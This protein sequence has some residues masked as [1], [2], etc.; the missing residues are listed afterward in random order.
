M[1]TV[2]QALTAARQRLADLPDSDPELDAQVLLARLLDKDRSWLYAWPEASL[3]AGQLAAFE[4]LVTRRAA[5]EPVAHLTGEREFWGLNLAVSADT[6][7][8][9][10]DTE[11]LVECALALGD[12]HAPLR[13]LDLG[14]GSGAIALALAHERPHWQIV[15]SDAAAAALSVARH[16]AARLGLTRVQFRQ[17]DWLDVVAA[18]ERFELILSNPPYIATVDPHLGRGDVRHEPAS[19]LISGSDGLDDIRALAD[20]APRHLEPGGWLALEHGFQQGAAVREL[21]R[22]A[23]LGAVETREDLAGRPRVTLGQ[24]PGPR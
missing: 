21:L 6:L 12:A 15:A 2:R 13:L 10:P 14:T 4:R 7:I 23:G 5:G 18:D 19:A 1:S 11:L 22:Q 20:R 9:R 24:Q 3:N 17:G 16:N 8:P